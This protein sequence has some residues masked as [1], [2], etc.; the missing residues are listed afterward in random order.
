MKWYDV[1]LIRSIDTGI[2]DGLNNPI[3][4]DIEDLVVKGRFI[5]WNQKEISIEDRVVLKNERKVFLRISK[6]KFPDCKKIVVGDET[7]TVKGIVKQSDRF[8]ELQIC[9]YGN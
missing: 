4:E 3:Y 1:K 8:I 5:P 2:K 7:Y 9:R 6:D